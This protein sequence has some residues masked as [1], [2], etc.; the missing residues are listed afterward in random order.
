MFDYSIIGGGIVGLSVAYTLQQKQ[1][2]ARIQIIE[3]E[4]E[5]ACHQTGNNSGV[6]HSG[7]YYKPGSF[8]ARF[9]KAGSESMRKFCLEHNLAID[10][11]GKVI[12][13]T[14]EKELEQLHTLYQRGLDNGLHVQLLSKQ[15]LVEIEPH[16]NGIAGIR[17]PT[18]GIVN[19]KQ[20]SETLAALFMQKGG[21]LTLSEE[22][23]SIEERHDHV[24]ISTDKKTY[25][26]QFVI[27]CAGL[28]S[29]RI[30]NLAGYHLDMKIIPF[31][32]EYYKL[33]PEKRYLVNHLIYPVPDPNFPFLGVHFT[34]MTNGEIDAGPNAVLS[35]KR[36]GYKKTDLNVRDLAE[37]LGYRGFWKIASKY[38][39]KGMEEMHRSYSK[40]V[41]VKSLQKLIPAVREDDLIP[42]SS[43]VRAQGLTVNGELVD[44]FHIVTGKRSLHICNAP[45]PAA[46][47]ALEIGKEVGERMERLARAK[48]L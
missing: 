12:V 8:K 18:A 30:A 13:A 17:V 9:A 27:N 28:H 7:I 47:A 14:E 20:V 24:S 38:M 23:R 2:E 22:V 32:G 45:S 41:F 15:E 37:T 26:T 43:G 48:V 31:R 6:I 33:K 11:C 34:R 16:V 5:V 3:K 39:Q 21:T 46:T 36:E 42:A 1:P 44:D 10:I 4:R 19:Y 40:K 25:S 35:F 29:D